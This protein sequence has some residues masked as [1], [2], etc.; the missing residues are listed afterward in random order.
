MRI[1][2]PAAR[3]AKS[4]AVYRT[5]ERGIYRPTGKIGSCA[6]I[7]RN[8]WA[9]AFFA[10]DDHGHQNAVEKHA[11]TWS[12]SG[13]TIHW[14]YQ[15]RP[16]PNPFVRFGDLAFAIREMDGSLSYWERLAEH[17]SVTRHFR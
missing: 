12:L 16:D 1:A 3:R 2:D 14:V 11:G 7:A 13:G 15:G 5:R 4:S 10:P 9:Q 6:A 8:P 17:E